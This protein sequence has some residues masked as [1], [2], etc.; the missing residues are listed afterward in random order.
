MNSSTLPSLILSG[1]PS[2]ANIHQRW[3]SG[4][5]LL[6]VPSATPFAQPGAFPKSLDGAQTVRDRTQRLEDERLL[7]EQRLKELDSHEPSRPPSRKARPSHRRNNTTISISLS[8]QPMSA[9]VPALSGSI[10]IPEPVYASHI[11]T[12]LRSRRASTSFRTQRLV[13]LEVTVVDWDMQ[14]LP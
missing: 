12:P 11:H 13:G 9:Y 10:H 14:G 3:H 5:S 2:A 7:L 6:G 8:S 4:A 1:S